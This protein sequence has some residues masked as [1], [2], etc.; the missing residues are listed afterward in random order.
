MGP[1]NPMRVLQGDRTTLSCQVDAN[2]PVKGIRWLLDGQTI[3]NHFNHTLHEVRLSDAG[4][5]ACQADN[6]IAP[7]LANLQAGG[8][9]PGSAPS[10]LFSFSILGFAAP[11]SS[12]SAPAKSSVE[13]KLQLEVLYPPRLQVR[14]LKSMPLSEGDQFSLNCS[15]DSSPPA[16]EFTWSKLEEVGGAQQV[17]RIATSSSP[18]LE[19]HSVSA[20]DMGNYTCTAVNRLEPSGQQQ[21]IERQSSAS[22]LVLVRHK[23]GLAEI[24]VGQNGETELTNKTQIVCRAKPPGYPEPSYKFWRYQKS[25]QKIHLNNPAPGPIYTIYSAKADDEAKYGCMASNELGLSNEADGDLIVQEPPSIIADSARLLEDSR[26]P[27]EHAFSINFRASGKPEPKVQWFHR[28]P[29]DGRR[30]PISG[31]EMMSRFKVETIARPESHHSSRPRFV[32]VSTLTFRSP[33]E[34]DDRG[35][36]SVEFGNNL[37]RVA[38]ADYQLRIHHP[39]IPA[40]ANLPIIAPRDLL[41]GA[42]SQS[43]QLERVTRTKAGFNV[44]ETVNLTCRVSAWPQPVFEWYSSATQDKPIG[45]D[46]RY[47]QSVFRLQDDI[48]MSSLTFELLSENEYGDYMCVS[49]NNNPQTNTISESIR[50][51]ISLA[52]KTVP[53]VPFSLEQVDASQDSVTIQWL[54]GFDGGFQQNQ[55]LVQFAPDDGQ[56][57]G[58]RSISAAPKETVGADFNEQQGPFP[59]LYNCLSMNPC[60]INNLLPRQGYLMRLQ[61]RNELG[62]G[63]FS[64]ELRVV[65]RANS[66]QIPRILDADYENGRNILHYR[67][68]PDPEYLLNNLNAK[69]EVRQVMATVAGG[70][71]QLSGGDELLPSDEWRLLSLVPIRQ[72][73][74]E[75]YLS[76]PS[77]SHGEQ[78]RVTL[79]SRTNESLCGPEYLVS[80]RSAASSFLQNQR[81]LSLSI[82]ISTLILILLVAGSATTLHSCCL[83]R[84]AKKAAALDR[85]DGLDGAGLANGLG[86][87][88]GNVTGETKSHNG[89]LGVQMNGSHK[90][91]HGS[92][93][94]TNSTSANGQLQ[95]MD[96]I[97]GHLNN[98]SNSDHS[99]DHSRQAKLDSMLPPNY[100]HYADRASLMLE[101][102]QQQQQQQ[103]YQQQQQ[104]YQMQTDKLSSPFG[105]PSSALLGGLNQG[106]PMNM[107][108]GNQFAYGQQQMS[109]LDHQQ[110]QLMM[111]GASGMMMGSVL[112]A[113]EPPATSVW[114]ASQLDDYAGYGN[115]MVGGFGG[116]QQ[117]QEQMLGAEPTYGTSTGLIMAP[118][119]ADFDNSAN[120]FSYSLGAY[121]QQQQSDTSQYQQE[122]VAAQQQMYGTLSRQPNYSQPSVAGATGGG[123][124]GQHQEEFVST[125]GLLQPPQ[126]APP[127]PPVESD[128]GTAGGRSGRLIREIIV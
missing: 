60:T 68:E 120:Q 12:D 71:N 21:A 93:T 108:L 30:R 53:D 23:P 103:A 35:L 37:S 111:D 122:I 105:L 27:G 117:G 89:G 25:G 115:P 70:S 77:E 91:S 40:P 76:L 84:R 15:A 101:Q 61:A 22:V 87:A 58:R 110:Q 2:P 67:I 54:P 83:S 127:P 72:D 8:Q 107:G 121:Q 36:Y 49:A 7:I 34:I 78:L 96:S 9:H 88:N 32:V 118:Q 39:P 20:S 100:N 80:M 73:R 41:T 62:A 102:Q 18:L 14:V 92:T 94:S 28:S 106:S 29:V 113:P 79:C 85:A 69:I 81:G 86:A 56:P 4:Q 26:P 24:I 90:G 128:Y 47:Q 95:S 19:F 109:S 43:N 75:V 119:P 66:S 42:Q 10:S 1:F 33:L 104:H 16:H 98:G 82:L 55:F 44:G 3:S 124:N 6:G 125:N 46:A 74:G 38:Q 63:D 48:F 112:E 65:T 114:P 59:R 99:S 11:T 31:T 17:R 123:P 51:V 126:P 50:I 64:E 13:A 97:T 116:Q 45:K 52:P 5:Y 57:L